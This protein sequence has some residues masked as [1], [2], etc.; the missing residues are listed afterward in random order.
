MLFSGHIIPDKG[1]KDLIRAFAIIARKYSEWKLVFAGNREIE[2]ARALADELGISEQ[3]VLLG[4]VSGERKHKAYSEARALCLPSYAEGFPMAVLEAWSYGLPVIATPVGGIPDIA[5]DGENMLLFNPG[6]IDA[7]ANKL[8]LIISDKAL[9]D[10]M[11]AESL[12]LAK[13]KFSL[14]SITNQVEEIYER[15]LK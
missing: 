9:R 2:Q 14:E 3:V 6:N 4:W 5:V 12:L 1:Y 8:E 13:G 11:S 7:L 15:V 10:K